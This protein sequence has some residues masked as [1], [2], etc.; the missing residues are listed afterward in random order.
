MRDRN[1]GLEESRRSQTVLS[2]NTSS[3]STNRLTGEGKNEKDQ[4][5]H[6]FFE[7]MFI[8]YYCPILLPYE[9]FSLA[10]W[11]SNYEMWHVGRIKC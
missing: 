5:P 7:L 1:A 2:L 11:Q 10:N 3:T 4:Q 9:H 8:L 6:P